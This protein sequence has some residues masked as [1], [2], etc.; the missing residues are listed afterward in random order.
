[1]SN[2]DWQ[3][4]GDSAKEG[5]KEGVRAVTGF[6][7]ALKDA[8]EETMRD[9]RDTGDLDPERARSAMRA[10]MKRAQEAMDDVKE[11]I[12]FVPRKEI[13]AL[14]EE[15]SALR[16]RVTELEMKVGGGPGTIPVDGA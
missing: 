5:I 2:D 13:D 4:K 9:V 15:I 12:D 1:M 11:R 14:N 10:T 16:A 7:A 3:R 6:L 8:I